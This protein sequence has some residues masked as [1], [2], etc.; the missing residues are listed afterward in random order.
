MANLN[1]NRD[2]SHKVIDLTCNNSVYVGSYDD[3]CEFIEEQ[4][5]DYFTYEISYNI[6]NQR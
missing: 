5:S 2:K 4:G 6:S 1:K 3:C